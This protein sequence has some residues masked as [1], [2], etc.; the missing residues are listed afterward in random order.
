M[1][2]GA[3][4]VDPERFEVRCGSEKIALTASEFKLLLA[5]D[6]HRG[7]VLTRENLISL[8]QGEGVSVV[9]R[10]VDT[11]VFGLRKK[12]G[13][14]ADFVETIRGIGYRIKPEE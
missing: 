7:R 9:G 8:V 2:I 12:L 5:L 13:N 3:L 1:K 11:H 10:A 4:F 6:R 14:C